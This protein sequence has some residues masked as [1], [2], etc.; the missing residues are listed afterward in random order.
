M[1]RNKDWL[2]RNERRKRKNINSDWTFTAKRLAR[3]IKNSKLTIDHL[4][5]KTN[6]W[7][8]HED[9]KHDKSA[10]EHRWKHDYLGTLL[11][12]EQILAILEENFSVLYEETSS[13]IVWDIEN[14]L[15]NHLQ[16]GTFYKKECFKEWKIPKE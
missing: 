8:N 3:I 15:R 10:K 7:T 5:A 14:I 9:N 11:P 4:I 6:H 2:T 12:H 1:R 13:E 16:K